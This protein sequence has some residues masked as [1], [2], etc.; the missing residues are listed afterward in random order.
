MKTIWICINKHSIAPDCTKIVQLDRQQSRRVLL[1][2]SLQ[3]LKELT[4][5]IESHS[6]LRWQKDGRNGHRS[7]IIKTCD[8]A[9]RNLA[10][11]QSVW[12]NVTQSVSQSVIQMGG[13]M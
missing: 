6:A 10:R 13:R 7:Q 3:N 4:P 8:D 1:H 12:Q 2:Q 11:C 5:Y 9:S